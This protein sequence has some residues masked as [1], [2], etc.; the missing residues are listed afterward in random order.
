MKPTRVEVCLGATGLCAL[1]GVT[2]IAPK[3]FIWFK[4][5]V[6]EQRTETGWQPFVPNGAWS[7]VEGSVWQP[8]YGCLYAVGWP[9]GLSTNATWR[10][11]VAY[12]REPSL[13]GTLINQ[14]LGWEIFKRGRQESTVISSEVKPE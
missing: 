9:P 11:R 4:A 5:S 3:E 7:G 2:N 12:G 14:K 8:G 10:L 1:F 13:L 6:V